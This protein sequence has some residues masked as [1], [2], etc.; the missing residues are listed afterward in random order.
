MFSIH[1]TIIKP[2]LGK[3]FYYELTIIIILIT[4]FIKIPSLL[5]LL[6]CGFSFDFHSYGRD[7]F[8]LENRNCRRS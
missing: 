4:I 6:G 7:E 5:F 2:T 1:V 3:V 8:L